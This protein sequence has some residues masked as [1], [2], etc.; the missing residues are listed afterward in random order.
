MRG[1]L[2]KVV[3]LVVVV[4]GLFAYLGLSRFFSS[5]VHGIGVRLVEVS[6]N[7]VTVG[8]AW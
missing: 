6:S 1:S 4:L 8:T 3:A 5:G 7:N 2:V